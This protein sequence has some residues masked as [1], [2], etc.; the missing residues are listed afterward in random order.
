MR[1]NRY[2]VSSQSRYH[3][4]T[5]VVPDADLQN[6]HVS[7]EHV[8]SRIIVCM[9]KVGIVWP[10]QM[11]LLDDGVFSIPIP[12]SP[13]EA[14]T[15]YIQILVRGDQESIPYGTNP[16]GGIPVPGESFCGGALVLRALEESHDIG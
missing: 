7:I 9:L 15:Y 11:D 16:A 3:E 14:G 8:T 13:V 4:G 1:S 6:A 10:W 5:T 2:R 12:V